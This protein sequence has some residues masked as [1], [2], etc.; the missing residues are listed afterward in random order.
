MMKVMMVMMA[1]FF[2][3][4]AAGLALYFIVSTTG[5]IIER[6]FIPKAGDKKASEAH[7]ANDANPSTSTFQT[8]AVGSS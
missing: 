4:V 5:G 3:K 6:Q 1:F 7:S 2:Y 8:S